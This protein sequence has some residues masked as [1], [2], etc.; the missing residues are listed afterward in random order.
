M[1]VLKKLT[2]VRHNLL[3]NSSNE[4]PGVVISE[5]SY[6]NGVETERYNYSSE[7]LLEDHV[8]IELENG[9]PVKETLETEGQISESVERVFDEKGRLVS[10]TKHYQEGGSDITNYTYEGDKLVL[11]AT[12]DSDGEEGEKEI[13]EYNDD[14][15]IKEIKVDL[16]GETVFE[17]E[18]EYDDE[19]HISSLTEISYHD[20]LPEKTISLYDEDGRLYVEKRYNGKGNLI[21]RTTIEYDEYNRPGLYEEENVRGK[22]LTSL[23]YDEAGNNILQEERAGDGELLSSVK[24]EYDSE[25]RQIFAEVVMQ[26]TLYQAGLHYKLKYLYEFEAS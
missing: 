23:K 26:P 3:G 18:Y 7:G 14:K 12:S 15:L 5:V 22:K 25:G 16:F 6:S 20:E 17:R 10:E 19:G 8:I 4:D 11:K 9:L 13:W 1:S 2:I 24:R 21:A